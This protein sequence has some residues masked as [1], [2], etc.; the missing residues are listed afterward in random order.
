[1]SFKECM[2]EL[3]KNIETLSN[4][5]NKLKLGEY[6]EMLNSPTKIFYSNFMWGLA[7]GIGMAIGFTLL[8][9]LILYILKEAVSVPLIGSFIAEIIK[10]V[11]DNLR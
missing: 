2:K 8:G 5:I 6:I 9:A 3:N 7:R 11:Q 10:I 1:M 4:N